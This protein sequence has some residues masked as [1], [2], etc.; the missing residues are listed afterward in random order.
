[1]S[2]TAR[3]ESCPHYQCN[4]KL[5]YLS[6]YIFKQFTQ[7]VSVYEYINIYIH[8]LFVRILYFLVLTSLM[9]ALV[10]NADMVAGLHIEQ[11]LSIS[12]S[13]NTT[14]YRWQI[15][16]LQALLQVSSMTCILWHTS[17]LGPYIIYRKV[18]E[19]TM[20]QLF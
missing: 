5:G 11:Q 2:R 6:N 3:Q 1:M 16:M 8:I 7:Y 4:D 9:C 10:V 18:D 12:D 15:C 13:G 20:K 14:S 17:I 19:A